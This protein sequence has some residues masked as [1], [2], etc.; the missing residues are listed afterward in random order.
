MCFKGELK[1]KIHLTDYPLLHVMK[2]PW[3]PAVK[4]LFW[5]GM[6]DVT[7]LDCNWMLD[8]WRVGAEGLH[9]TPPH[10]A[11]FVSSHPSTVTKSKMAA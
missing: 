4:V 6:F 1:N 2:A 9:L 11:N 10:T 5:N 7:I 3:K 8:W